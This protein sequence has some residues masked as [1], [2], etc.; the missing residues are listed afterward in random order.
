MSTFVISQILVGIAFLFDLATFQFKDRRGIILCLM[1]ST[2]L[3]SVHFFLLQHH[4]AAILLLIAVVRF[5]IS[6]FTTS[7]PVMWIMFCISLG[8]IAFTYYGYLSILAGAASLIYS[9]AAFE[10]NDK[11]IRIALMAATIIWIVH[12]YFAQTPAAMALNAFFFASNVIGYYRY[13]G[14]G[15]DKEG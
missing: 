7:R 3:L 11:T 14:R 6:Y 15:G 5:G 2:L 10:K 8:A 9:W 13:Y 1:S 4:T 12:D